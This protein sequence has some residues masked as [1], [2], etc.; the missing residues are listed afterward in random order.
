MS[1]SEENNMMHILWMFIHRWGGY[2]DWKEYGYPYNVPRWMEL[3]GTPLNDAIITMM[4]FVPKFKINSGVQKVNVVFLTDGASRSIDGVMDIELNTTDGSHTEYT[5]TFGRS[6]GNIDTIITDPVIK[7][8]YS[9]PSNRG[10]VMTDKL[11]EILK[12][13]IDGMNVVGFFLAGTGR[14][15]RVDKRT[16]G[17][18]TGINP[19]SEEMKSIIREVNKEKFFAITGDTTGYDEYYILAGGQ[20]LTPE[21][22]TLSD[23][24]VGAGKGKL[25]SAFGKMQKG[26]ISSRVLLNRFIK[27]VA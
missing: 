22:E 2:R 26:K 13:R 20:S 16:L 3:G 4:D 7:K 15:G 9:L 14:S 19:Y 10:T 17:Y 1:L 6:F 27:M 5:K 11:L 12:N 23:S 25:K 24:L 21:N 18:L 8:S